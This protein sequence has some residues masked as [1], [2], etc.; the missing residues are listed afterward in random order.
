MLDAIK[1]FFDRHI[2]REDETSGQAADHRARVAVAALLIETVRMDDHILEEERQ[3]VLG[4]IGGKFA[5]DDRE[6]AELVSLAEEE[7][8]QATDFFQFTSQI[9]QAFS[10]EQKVKLIEH[11]WRVAYADAVLHKYEEHLIRKIADLIYV[12]HQSFI[13]AKHRVRKERRADE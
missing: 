5:L 1:A 2:A 10:L 7:V 12:P 6:A 9:N 3:Q 4:S 13:A 8:H 11:M